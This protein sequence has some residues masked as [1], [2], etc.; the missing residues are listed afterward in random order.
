MSERKF[1]SVLITGGAGFL[2]SRLVRRYLEQ[3]CRVLAVGRHLPPWFSGA[4]KDRLVS[5]AEVDIRD[6]QALAGIVPN[7]DL[8]V[9]AAAVTRSEDASQL[10]L[11]EEINI[12]GTRNVIRACELHGL[13]R[14]VHV[15]TVSTIEPSPRPA[16]RADEA[17]ALRCAGGSRGYRESKCHAELLVRGAAASGL[18][19][20]VVNPGFM[21]GSWQSQYRGAEVIR[22]PLTRRVV[23]CT[24]GGLSIVHV[25]DAADGIVQAAATGRSGERYIL[26]GDNV[27]FAGIARVVQRVAGKTGW[28][29]TIPNM[30]ARW[31]GH[32]YAFYSSAK[33]RAEIGFEPRAFE[34]IVRDYLRWAGLQAA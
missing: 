28:T 27:T 33:A 19:A 6:A 22:R 16:S 29:V 34:E 30:G 4:Y 7:H 26:S 3:G 32:R 1:E 9:H 31:P 15:S 18:D 11:Q 14:L 17:Q 13:S 10:A 5:F 23:V 24:G 20:V 21:F 12:E 8:V 25:E 2:G